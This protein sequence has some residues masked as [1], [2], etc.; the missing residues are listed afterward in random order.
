MQK[1]GIPEDLAADYDYWASLPSWL[2]GEFVGLLFGVDPDKSHRLDG[3]LK[4]EHKRFERRA[5]RFMIPDPY[6]RQ[7]PIKWF[8][9][10]RENGIPIPSLLISSVEAKTAPV[11]SRDE[12]LQLAANK[13]ADQKIQSGIHRPKKR[14]IAQEL[15]VSGEWGDLSS[16]RILRLLRKEW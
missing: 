10:A 6:L 4:N 11:L 8:Q 9:W 12:K 13:L 2:A 1:S 7:P 3:E 16:E 15:F 5:Y 14:E